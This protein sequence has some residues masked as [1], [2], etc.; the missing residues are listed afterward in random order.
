[1]R[2]TSHT[3]AK[4]ERNPAPL[5]FGSEGVTPSAHLPAR[6]LLARIARALSSLHRS[7]SGLPFS[8]VCL[9]RRTGAFFVRGR[10]L[11][12]NFSL[13]TE[14]PRTRRSTQPPSS[15]ITSAMTTRSPIFTARPRRRRGLRHSPS[16][17]RMTSAS[18]NPLPQG[19]HSAA[20]PS[21]L[22]FFVQK[23]PFPR[24]RQEIHAG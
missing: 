4:N 16:V 19:T 11:R 2:N 13:T 23:K 7:R 3:T 21:A 22:S 24:S 6:N 8:M 1:M 18:I 12:P 10:T 14:Q 15:R 17:Q 9:F 20:T 5:T